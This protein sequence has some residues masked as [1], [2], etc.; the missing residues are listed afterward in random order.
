MITIINGLLLFL[1]AYFSMVIFLPVFDNKRWIQWG[2]G[3]EECYQLNRVLFYLIFI[4]CSAPF[5]LGQFS[6]IKYSIYFITLLLLISRGMI[7]IRFNS[8]VNAYIIFLLWL[9]I[10]MIWSSAP[11][12][13]ILLL[14]KYSIPLLSLWLGYSA[15]QGEYDLY[16]F[17]KYV[18]RYSLIYAL[19]LGG[20]SAVFAPSLYF[21][22]N[23]FFLTYAGLADYFTA[24]IGL[25]FVLNWLTFSHKHYLGAV[26]LLLSTLLEVVRTGLGGITIVGSMF[27][28]FRYKLKAIPYLFFFGIMFLSIVLFVPKVNEKFFGNDAGKVTV[29]DIVSGGAMSSDK[30]QTSGRE[31]IWDV[32]LR[33]F[34]E[35]NKI[36][37]AGLGSSTHYLKDKKTGFT[38]V[39]ITLIHSD[40]VQL[41]CDSGIVSVVLLGVFF[42]VLLLKA[43]AIALSSSYFYSKMTAVLAVS[44]MSGVAFSMGYDNVVSH[45]MTSL[46]I[47]FIFI[48]FFMKYS[49]LENEY[50]SE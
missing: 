20:I 14:I 7:L 5:F 47:P 40:Y 48:G 10:T 32:L 29:T 30:I 50:V 28:L 15:I 35:P 11:F 33:K 3:S 27:S 49:E 16:F 25:F 46:I 41:L 24:I 37:G 13:A 19:F 4:I 45:S 8:I 44:S 2:K 12:D 23:N 31:Y 38:Q 43:G 21:F 1:F 17:A 9:A 39:K 6:I 34:Y 18:T 26:W 36:V 42:L 22:L